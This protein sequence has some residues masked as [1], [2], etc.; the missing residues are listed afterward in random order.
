MLASFIVN[1]TQAWVILEEG[2]S[3]E[4]M[5]PPAWPVGKADAFS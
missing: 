1:M 3:T 4:E 5:F 2:T